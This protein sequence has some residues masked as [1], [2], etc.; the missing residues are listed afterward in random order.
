M[1]AHNVPGNDSGGRISP[2]PNVHVK[3]PV[4][5][6]NTGKQLHIYQQWSSH[7]TQ[8]KQY[9]TAFTKLPEAF[10]LH[11]QCR[12]KATEEVHGLSTQQ[13]VAY[14]KTEKTLHS[15]LCLHHTTCLNIGQQ[16][17]LFLFII[18]PPQLC[19]PEPLER[20]GIN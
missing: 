10:H 12:D 16:L 20:H 5:L 9:I 7:F 11:L 2:V 4:H 13:I 1:F 14:S 18:I 8:G 15:I 3:V 6:Q 19:S 17:V